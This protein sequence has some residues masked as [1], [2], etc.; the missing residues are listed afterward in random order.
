MEVE[1]GQKRG[2]IKPSTFAIVCSRIGLKDQSIYS[3]KISSLKKINF[4]KPPH[5]IIIPGKLH[6]TESDALK[7]LTKCLDVPFDNSDKIKKISSQMLE[8][9]IPMIRDAI[10]EIAPLYKNSKKFKD[11]LINAELYIKDAQKFLDEGKDEVAILCVGYA[12]GLVDALRI[13][14]GIEPKT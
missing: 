14:K 10:K 1:K 7:L 4:R 5:S 13:G 11:V 6:F 2:V 12:D 9:Y 8:K 3:G